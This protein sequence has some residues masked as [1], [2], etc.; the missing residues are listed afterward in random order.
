M[1]KLTRN[2]HDEA[3]HIYITIN[4]TLVKMHRSF[5]FTSRKISNKSSY[6]KTSFQGYITKK[7]ASQSHIVLNQNV[8]GSRQLLLARDVTERVVS[9]H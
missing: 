1:V 9:G 4:Q 7:E 3:P 6:K 5:Q 8:L 2:N